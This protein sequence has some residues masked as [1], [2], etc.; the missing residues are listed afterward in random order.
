MLCPL[1]ASPK[2]VLC[3][4]FFPGAGNQGLR[5]VAYGYRYGEVP[6]P[7]IGPIKQSAKIEAVRPHD[8]SVRRV[9]SVSLGAHVE[10]AMNAKPDL[11]HPMTGIAGVRKRFCV[12]PPPTDPKLLRSIRKFVR[13]FLRRHL[14][15]LDPTTDLSLD[16]W[17]DGTDYTEARKAELRRKYNELV[18]IHDPAEKYRQC[19][20]FIKDEFYTALKHARAI[21]SR[22]DE[23]KCVVGPVFKAI[24]SVV[25]D[26]EYDGIKPFIKHVPVADRPRTILAGL[27]GVGRKYIATD[28]TAFESLFV[29]EVMIAV[30]CQLYSYMTS[31]LPFHS[32]FCQII[33]TILAGVNKCKFKFFTIVV[34]ATRMSGE[35]C[36]SLGNGFANL[37]FMLFTASRAGCRHIRGFVEGDDGLFSM[38]GTPPSIRDFER[39]GLIIKL[40]IH[41]TLSTASFCGIIFDELDQINVT[42]PMKV[43]LNFGWTS[44]Q[45]TCSSKRKHQILLRAK[46]LS[47][48]YQYP[49]CPII[50]AMSR[51]I[52]RSTRHIRN[53]ELVSTVNRMS[54]DMYHR[55]EILSAVTRDEKGLTIRMPTSRTRLLMQQKYGV[56]VSD[57][58]AIESYFNSLTGVTTINCP[59]IMRY[60]HPWQVQLFRTYAVQ[61]PTSIGQ[62]NLD[63]P[64]STWFPKMR[65]F[66]PEFTVPLLKVNP[67]KKQKVHVP[68]VRPW[69]TSPTNWFRSFF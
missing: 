26:L 37:M 13:R 62:R 1:D 32:E 48:A 35:M 23:F 9:V 12:R 18:N 5:T 16:T 53:D 8:E 14:K 30:E 24:E 19:K 58:Y 3:F 59:T 36:T 31:K 57:Q 65:G 38:I 2:R 4:G 29:R 28:Y 25:Y 46:A 68:F 33:D 67:V 54:T 69:L 56:F 45:Y 66:V 50:D 20:S 47:Y 27:S 60:V 10:G 40:E 6:L 17:L 11:Y 61:M 22:S 41:D 34:N 21:N 49:G 55:R 15:P 64:P 44:S 7:P 43:L 39:L 51:W 42:D 52:L 63:R